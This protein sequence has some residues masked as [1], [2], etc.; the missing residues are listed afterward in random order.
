[1]AAVA[2]LVIEDK[3]LEGEEGEDGGAEPQMELTEGNEEE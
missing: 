3:A 1:V 2:R